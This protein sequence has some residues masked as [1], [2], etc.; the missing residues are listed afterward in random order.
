MAERLAHFSEFWPFYVCEHSAPLTRL[1]HFIGT[2]TIIP[3]LAVALWI[4]P[5]FVLLIPVSAY[6]FA[7]VAHFFVE[8]NRPATFTY[9]LW[10][11][12]GDLRMF[13]LMCAGRMGAEVERCRQLRSRAADNRD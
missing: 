8:R 9:P 1:L 6:G 4:D 5:L 7:W 10:S 13:G 12:L 11:L 3:L 2:G